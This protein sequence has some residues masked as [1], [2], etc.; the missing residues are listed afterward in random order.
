MD[1]LHDLAR[2]AL[3]EAAILDAAKDLNA[4]TR[5]ELAALLSRGTTHTVF[6]ADESVELGKVIMSNPKPS[7]RV[8][9][10]AALIEWVEAKHPGALVYT[11]S[12]SPAWLKGLLAKG[13][14]DDG[15]VPPGVVEVTGTPSLQVR[16]SD[17]ARALARG[18]VRKALE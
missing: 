10:M 12:I 5:E 14:D 11:V 7:T 6:T 3:G 1:P 13:A 18:L 8:V 4:A 16:P 2:R 15:E 9:D 17:D